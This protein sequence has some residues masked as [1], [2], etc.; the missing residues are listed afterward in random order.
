VRQA[1]LFRLLT[2][3]V[4]ADTGTI[5]VNAAPLSSSPQALCLHGA[6][7]EIAFECRGR[8]STNVILGLEVQS[9]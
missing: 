6:Q 3:R 2:R 1:S 7:R 5:E 4:A 9:M 8:S